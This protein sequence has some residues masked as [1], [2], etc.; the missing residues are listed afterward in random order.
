ML[1][2]DINERQSKILKIVA[3]FEPITGERI[4]DKLSMT[5]AAL[6][7]DLAVLTISGYLE[8]KPRVG[9]TINNNR[10]TNA[11]GKI[12]SKYLV[13]DIQSVPT[14]VKSDAS[15][16]DA[17]VTLFTEDSGSLFIVDNDNNLCGVVSRKDLLKTTLGK[18]DIHRMPISVIMTRM[19]NVIT[20]TQNDNV[21]EAVK[22]LVEHEVDSL[23]VVDLKING[24]NDESTKVVGKVSKTNIIRMFLDLADR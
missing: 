10:S 9:Y 3:D 11:F 21:L 12:I 23:P 18:A 5:R 20:V 24:E 16:Y 1:I 13:K 15:I 14:V 17:I 19:P 7:P 4:A 22:K 6:R 2:I 8:A